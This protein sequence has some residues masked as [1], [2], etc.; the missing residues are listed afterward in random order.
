MH[1]KHKKTA[2]EIVLTV[3]HAGGK[4][5]GKNYAVSGGL[6]GVGASVVNALSESLVATV[7]REG[8]EYTQTYARGIPQSKLKTVGPSRKHGTTIAF[9]PDPEIFG[10]SLRFD[11]ERIKERL[12]HADRE[13]LP[14]VEEQP[15]QAAETK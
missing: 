8:S 9:R 7:R 14:P 5:E 3:L 4:F 2:L 13:I 15:Q 12:E 1:P 10:K 6:H 11:V